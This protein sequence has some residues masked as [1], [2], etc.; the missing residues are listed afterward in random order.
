MVRRDLHAYRMSARTFRFSGNR[1]CG[2]T[3]ALA[4]VTGVSPTCRTVRNPRMN[5]MQ[6]DRQAGNSLRKAY[7]EKMPGLSARADDERAGCDAVE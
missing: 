4:D 7:P 5:P 6:G 1:F 3:L 2:R